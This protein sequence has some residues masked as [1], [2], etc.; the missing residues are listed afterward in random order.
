M[1]GLPPVCRAVVSISRHLS[2]MESEVLGARGKVFT[3]GFGV[4][5]AGSLLL[6]EL[7]HEL[8]W[9]Q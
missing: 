5:S 3:N 9:K 7:L 4:T 6:L 1:V 8:L 2:L